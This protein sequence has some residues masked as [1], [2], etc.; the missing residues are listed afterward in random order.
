MCACGNLHCT[1]LNGTSV[2]FEH[3]ESWREGEG[4]EGEGEGESESVLKLQE[5]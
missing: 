4:E 3:L 2:L 1:A 5:I